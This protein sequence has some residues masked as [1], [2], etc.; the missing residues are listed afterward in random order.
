MGRVLQGVTGGFEFFNGLLSAPLCPAL[1][2][3]RSPMGPSVPG[4][5]AYMPILCS[6][7]PPIS[8]YNSSSTQPFKLIDTIDITFTIPCAQTKY[9]QCIC[10]IPTQAGCNTAFLVQNVG[11]RLA[12]ICISFTLTYSVHEYIKIM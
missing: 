2:L 7:C 10:E 5:H 9:Q 11:W 4:S 1:T 8:P 12:D 6:L 3:G